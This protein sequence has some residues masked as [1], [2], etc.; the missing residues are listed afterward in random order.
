MSTTT[1]RLAQQHHHQQDPVVFGWLLLALREAM[2]DPVVRT[3]ILEHDLGTHRGIE[4][5]K[6]FEY[7]FTLKQLEKYLETIVVK[8]GLHYLLFTAQNL[9]DKTSRETHYQTYIVDYRDKKVWVIDPA[10]TP[11][12]KGVYFAYISEDVV[13]PFFQRHGWST[14][15]APTSSACQK[16]K[17]DVFCQ[18]WSLYLQI[19]FMKRLLSTGTVQELPIPGRKEER[20]PL[21]VAFFQKALSIQLV[22]DQVTVSYQHLIRTHRD[23]VRGLESAQ[24]KKA[25]RQSYLALDP[26]ELLEKMTVQDLE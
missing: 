19:E 2:G 26:C 20:Y 24:Q 7:G 1:R 11:T 5:G 22:C 23:L 14:A 25:I 15:F 9:P 21:L 6:T 8:T 3:A 16:G 18:S 12:G 10:R 13:I 4:F 17:R